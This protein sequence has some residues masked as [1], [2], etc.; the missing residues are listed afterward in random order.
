MRRAN[1]LSP[2]FVLTIT[3]SILCSLAPVAFI[4]GATSTVMYITP[5]YVLVKAQGTFI[6]S[7]V[8]AD[9]PPFIV[10]QAVLSYDNSALEALNGNITIPWIGSQLYI[11]ND[12]GNITMDGGFTPVPLQG[13]QTLATVEFQALEHGNS[14]L[15]LMETNLLDTGYNA[16]PH[17]TEDAFVEAVGPITLTVA[18][19]KNHFYAGTNITI[20]G[21][22]T[23]AGSPIGTLVGLEL[24][25]PKGTSIVRTITTNSNLP[26]SSWPINITEFYPSNQYGN[27]T[28]SFMAGFQAYFTV[29]IQN[30]EDHPLPYIISISALDKYN[31]SI[32]QTFSQGPIQA[33]ST[34][35]LIT[36]VLL[37]YSV[38]NGTATAFVEVLS[39]WPHNG[40]FPYCPEQLAAFY[41]TDG[42][43]T[44][45]FNVPYA[46]MTFHSDYSNVFNLSSEY[47][48]GNYSVWASTEYKEIQTATANTTFF[49]TVV[50]DFNG[51]GKVSGPDLNRL[52]VSYGSTPQ[53]ANWF[54][55]ADF[56]LD[57]R[58]TGPDLNFLLTRYGS[59]I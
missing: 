12:R 42:V 9:S 45:P 53:K 36:A 28:N 11:Y 6:V 16:I 5:S 31:T 40:G 47:S 2:F 32:G 34:A 23:I 51:D 46:N 43:L 30:M 21:N 19:M 48:Y 15:H 29:Q 4:T 1:N 26:Q 59:H 54:Q 58:I 7:I 57:G 20:S 56:N 8:L 3:L 24:L 25:S 18:S 33:G 41:I 27:H 39:N 35:L 17:A 50:C 44:K 52:L 13:N 38:R 10:F 22:A 49:S 55:E 37:P 14:T